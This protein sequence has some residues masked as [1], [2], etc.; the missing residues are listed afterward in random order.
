MPVPTLLIGPKF[1]KAYYKLRDKGKVELPVW[2]MQELH[3]AVV[4]TPVVD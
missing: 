1:D 2:K 4:Q 3:A